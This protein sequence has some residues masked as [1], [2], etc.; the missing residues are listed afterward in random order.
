LDAFK[1]SAL[2]SARTPQ[3]RL[4]FCECPPEINSSRVIPSILSALNIR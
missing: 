4:R 2:S 3:K 1:K